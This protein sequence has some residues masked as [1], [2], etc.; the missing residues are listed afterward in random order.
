M[1]SGV[2]GCK[3]HHHDAKHSPH[4]TW[5]QHCSTQC[6]GITGAAKHQQL[7]ACCFNFLWQLE[8]LTF[9][10]NPQSSVLDGIVWF[11]WFFTSVFLKRCIV[12]SH[13]TFGDQKQRRLKLSTLSVISKMQEIVI[14]CDNTSLNHFSSHTKI[15][16]LCFP[17]TLP[18]IHICQHSLWKQS[19][20]GFW[21]QGAKSFSWMSLKMMMARA[22]DSGNLSIHFCPSFNLLRD[23]HNEP[24]AWLFRSIFLHFKMSTKKQKDHDS[25]LHPNP[26]KEKP[27]L[28]PMNEQTRMIEGFISPAQ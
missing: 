21:S 18:G 13:H 3:Q 20:A 22:D 16:T 17:P 4:E 10:L 25:G 26:Q 5:T 6:C 7:V 12:F 2:D 23:N 15:V 24:F 19:H 1:S 27:S 11:N 28:Q 9:V 8:G 14:F